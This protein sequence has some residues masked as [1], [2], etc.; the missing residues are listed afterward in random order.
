MTHFQPASAGDPFAPAGINNA[1]IPALS[2]GHAEDECFGALHFVRTGVPG[3]TLLN[4][5]RQVTNTGEH[6]KQIFEGAQLFDLAELGQEVLQREA[7]LAQ[8]GLHF[9]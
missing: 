1:R 4:T 5:V 3:K 7:V 2:R 8:G 6:F 9:L